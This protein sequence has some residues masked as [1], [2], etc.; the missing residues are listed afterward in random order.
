MLCSKYCVPDGRVYAETRYRHGKFQ[1]IG[2]DKLIERG[3]EFLLRSSN[4]LTIENADD[5]EIIL[6][7]G[8]GSFNVYW[9]GALDAAIAYRE[10][11][12]D[13]LAISSIRLRVYA[14]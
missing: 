11:Y 1:G 9:F 7:N 8:G 6:I 10:K 13:A 12:N 2:H 14:A 4:V 3:A 5:A